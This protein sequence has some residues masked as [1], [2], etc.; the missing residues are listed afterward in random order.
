MRDST[1]VSSGKMFSAGFQSP[2]ERVIEVLTRLPI[3]QILDYVCCL[4]VCFVKRG[5]LLV[6]YS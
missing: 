1:T 4:S 5:P 3:K 6:S 2:E